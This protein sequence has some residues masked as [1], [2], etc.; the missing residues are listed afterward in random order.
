MSKPELKIVL[1]PIENLTPYENNAKK[2]PKDQVARIAESIRRH[3]WTSAIV[4]DGNGI[5]IA[6]HGRRLAALEL[7]L[8][9]VPVIVMANL[10][11]DE[12]KAARLA[13]NRVG[14]SDIDSDMLRAE[15]MSL[16]MDLRG[17]FDEKELDF[18][19]ADLGTMNTDAFVT[20]MGAVLDGQR[21]DIADRME[22]STGADAR[23]SLFRAF[24][25]K[26]IPADG[27][28]SITNL[29]AK[30]EAAT[31]LKN[32]AALVAFAASLE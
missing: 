21:E 29:M 16:D 15:L 18:L 20:D 1:W 32:E 25:F 22:K 23:V 9:K 3:G 13:D 10:T 26:D 5:I 8:P 14:I 2:H 30:A 12:V 6:G 17:I 11:P 19:S 24:G 7:G 31:G 27:Q 28:I 4:V